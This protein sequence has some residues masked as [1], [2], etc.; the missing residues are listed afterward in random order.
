[1]IGCRH[2]LAGQEDEVDR[3]LD[4]LVMP[5]SYLTRTAQATELAATLTMPLHAGG[6]PHLTEPSVSSR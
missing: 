6:H 4:E 5:A 2:P 1:M 3:S